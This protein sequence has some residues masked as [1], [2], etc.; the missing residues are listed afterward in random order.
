MASPAN[1]SRRA[2]PLS[3]RIRPNKSARSPLS[4][5]ACHASSR[6][7]SGWSAPAIASGRSA[8]AES[9]E[10]RQPGAQ[11]FGRIARIGDRAQQVA[12]LPRFVGVVE[13]LLHGRAQRGCRA[14]RARR[15]PSATPCACGSE[16]RSRAQLA[17]SPRARRS[18]ISSA[19]ARA[20]RDR[21]TRIGSFCSS[22]A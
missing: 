21:T 3:S 4:A 8:S 6:S 12:D 19:M 11:P 17:T 20:S 1:S 15:R 13:A 9:E 22:S 10:W 14:R 5:A 2:R 16:R 7:I 18:A